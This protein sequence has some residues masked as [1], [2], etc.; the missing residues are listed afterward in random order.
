VD[1]APGKDDDEAGIRPRRE[2]CLAAG[3]VPGETLV[4]VDKIL[5]MTNP[6]FHPFLVRTASGQAYTVAHPELYWMD[7]DGEVMLVKDK[8]QGVAL[9]DIASV[10]EC[11]RLQPKAPPRKGRERT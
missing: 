3:P 6:P 10:T 11:V 9:I 4:D 8:K 1:D 7:P 2:T 5:S